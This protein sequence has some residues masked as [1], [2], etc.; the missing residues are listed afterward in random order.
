[1]GNNTVSVRLKG[2]YIYV[3]RGYGNGEMVNL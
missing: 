1:M 2:S 3:Y